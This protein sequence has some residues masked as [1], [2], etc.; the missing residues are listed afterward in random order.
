MNVVFWW[1]SLPC[2]LRKE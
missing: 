2:D 1:I